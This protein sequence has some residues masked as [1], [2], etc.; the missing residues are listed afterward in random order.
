MGHSKLDK[1]EDDRFQ[2]SCLTYPLHV[3]VFT[4]ISF[5]G[6]ASSDNMIATLTLPT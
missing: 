4:L 6:M 3:E 1:R 5:I 2:F